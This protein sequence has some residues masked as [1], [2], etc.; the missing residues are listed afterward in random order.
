MK[1]DLRKIGS[2]TYDSTL[3][4]KPKGGDLDWGRNMKSIF[5]SGGGIEDFNKC[6]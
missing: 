6:Q 5:L 4:Q 3:P 2:G 1:I